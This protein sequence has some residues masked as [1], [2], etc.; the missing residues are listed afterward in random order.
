MAL[1]IKRAVP[2]LRLLGLAL[3]IAALARPQHG[4]EDPFL[5]RVCMALKEETEQNGVS[6]RLYSESLAKCLAVHLTRRYARGLKPAGG[7]EK[8]GG[9]APQ[10]MRRAIEFI[11]LQLSEDFS[12]AEIAAEMG[13]SPGH[14]TR[15]FKRS[16]G[17][18]P[19]QYALSRR[20]EAAK[21]RMLEG[22]L[23]LAQIALDVGFYDQ[24]HFSRH[25]KRVNGITPV[26][27][28][29]QIRAGKYGNGGREEGME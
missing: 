9:L 29:R 3:V 8:P 25:F 12:V 11:N 16:M 18:P 24:A 20:I 15:L 21:Q 6:G 1:R 22:K 28:L 17:V 27:F 13:L 2:W 4:I 14:F 23:S 19:Y 7:P 5:A 10:A 26:E